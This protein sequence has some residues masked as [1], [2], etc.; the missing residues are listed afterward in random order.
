M[1][2]IILR[3]NIFSQIHCQT[4]QLSS[5]LDNGALHFCHHKDQGSYVEEVILNCRGYLTWQEA[6]VPINEAK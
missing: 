1:F 6:Q 2:D 5:V 3:L 4:T